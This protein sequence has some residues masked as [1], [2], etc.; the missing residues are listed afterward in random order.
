MAAATAALENPI[1]AKATARIK[2]FI[3]KSSKNTA[4]L[5]LVSDFFE[6]QDKLERNRD[7]VRIGAFRDQLGNVTPRRERAAISRNVT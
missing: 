1:A 7:I 6:L 4:S 2:I 5:H 3:I